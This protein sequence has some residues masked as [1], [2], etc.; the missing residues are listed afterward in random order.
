MAIPTLGSA[1]VVASVAAVGLG[2]IGFALLRYWRTVGRSPP[3]ADRPRA[4]RPIKARGG[5]GGT[6]TSARRKARAA[7][8]D[9]P[10]L[11]PA[12]KV[13]RGTRRSKPPP[14]RS[15]SQGR[16]SSQGAA[17]C[18]GGSLL[19]EAESAECDFE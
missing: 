11:P 3:S 17:C 7:G 6:S 15:G 12:K 2:A 16:R 19:A 13:E 18:E 1:L 14:A 5:V 8:L 9:E 4:K 10:P